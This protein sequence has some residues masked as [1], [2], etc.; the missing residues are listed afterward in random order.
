MVRNSEGD[1][2]VLPGNQT[3]DDDG[4][5]LRREP[6]EFSVGLSAAVR[7]ML[8]VALLLLSANYV[9]ETWGTIRAQNLQYP[10]FVI[11]SLAVLILLVLIDEFRT[12]QSMDRDV[13]TVDALNAYVDEWRVSILFAVIAV[14]YVG[15]ISVTGFFSASVVA[16]GA[17][18]YVAGVREYRMGLIVTV[19]VLGLVWLMFVELVGINPPSG[20][21][22]GLVI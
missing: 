14:V 2:D 13:R 11:G 19:G 12:L 21:I 16:M 7:L 3:T 6:V 9:R 17:A 15:L 20:I 5:Q 1:G 18:M 4:N 8:P 10:Y 22:D